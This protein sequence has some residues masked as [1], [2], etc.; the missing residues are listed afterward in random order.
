MNANTIVKFEWVNYNPYTPQQ[1]QEFMIVGG[2]YMLEF[3]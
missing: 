2:V 3:Y 1:R